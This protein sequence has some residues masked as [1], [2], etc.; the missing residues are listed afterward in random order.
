MDLATDPI[1]FARRT[2]DRRISGEIHYDMLGLGQRD[3]IARD[4]FVEIQDGSSDHHPR[5]QFNLIDARVRLRKPD[6][7]GFGCG[8]RIGGVV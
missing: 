1:A 5:C 4:G 2:L 6:G 3:S 7:D 8:I